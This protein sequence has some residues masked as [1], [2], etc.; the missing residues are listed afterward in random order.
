MGPEEVMNRLEGKVAIVTGGASGM[1]RATVLRF[2]SEG[3]ARGRGRL[4][5]QNGAERRDRARCPER[6]PPSSCAATWPKEPM[7]RHCGG[8][9]LRFGHL[10]IAY[11]NAGVGGASAPIAETSVEDWDYTLRCAARSS[12]A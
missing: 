10:D 9:G 7:S 11:L 4:N 2:L 12:S 8:G 6:R 3:R 5:E 1:G